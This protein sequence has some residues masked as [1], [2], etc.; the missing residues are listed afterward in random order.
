MATQLKNISTHYTSSRILRMEL[1]CIATGMLMA[2][3][4]LTIWNGTPSARARIFRHRWKATNPD[5]VIT[6]KSF[7]LTGLMA[8]E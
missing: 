1:C 5:L 7:L 3:P 4:R 6:V 8:P 2:L